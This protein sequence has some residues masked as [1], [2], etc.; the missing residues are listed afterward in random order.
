[1]KK[2]DINCKPTSCE[3]WAVASAASKLSGQACALSARHIEDGILRTQFN[4]EVAYYA[5][6][7]VRDVESGEKSPEQGLKEI[8][9]EHTSLIAQSAE[10]ASKGVGVVAG[11]MQ[12]AA[13]AGICY[14]SVGTL[15]LIA[16]VP[17]MAHGANN[18]YENG[19]NIV[20]RRSN[21]EGP[22]RKGY[23]E[24]A[25]MMGGGAYEGNMAYGAVDL[26]TSAVGILRKVVKEDA[27]RLFRYVHTDYVRAFTVTSKSALALEAVSDGFTMRSMYTAEKK[28]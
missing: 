15:C 18:V 7:I 16:G 4:R 24:V 2:P 23:Q 25:I 19:R 5:R 12:V 9:D 14:A 28:Q 13:G 26:A 27:W 3:Y 6:G 17:M 20:E 8:R 22:V 21:V 10:I 1:M 11:A